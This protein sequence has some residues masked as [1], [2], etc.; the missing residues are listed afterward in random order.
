M[1]QVAFI[2]WDV[3]TQ[4]EIVGGEG[5]VMSAG[6]GRMSHKIADYV[7]EAWTGDEGYFDTGSFMLKKAARSQTGSRDWRSWIRMATATPT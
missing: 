3:V 4:R 6:V 5:E 2:L 7:F 1:V